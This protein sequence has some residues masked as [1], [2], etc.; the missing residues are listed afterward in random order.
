MWIW[1]ERL[2][3]S[4]VDRGRYLGQLKRICE[5]FPRS[6]LYVAIFEDMSRD[7][8]VVFEEACRHIGVDAHFHPPE[9]GRKINAHVEF[10]SP[11]LRRIAKRFPRT[12]ARGVDRLNVRRGPYEPMSG[13]TRYALCQV[14]REEVRS[15]EEW[16]G[17]DLSDWAT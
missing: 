13:D 15:L 5:Y 3:F 7:A 14:F 1:R 16:L 2:V 9:L 8:G 11:G 4:Y 6:S 10:R 12:L 17:R